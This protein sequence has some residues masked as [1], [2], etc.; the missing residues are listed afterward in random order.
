MKHFEKGNAKPELII[1]LAAPVGT[2]LEQMQEFI[3]EALRAYRYETIPVRVSNLI[4]A[5]CDDDTR[6]LISDAK[7]DQRIDLLMDAGDAIRGHMN[8]GSALVPVICT[9]I[10]EIRKQKLGDFGYKEDLENLE[11][12]NH[13][14]VVNS[15]K[16]PDEVSALRAV[17][18][19]KIVFIS[20]FSGVE[21][22]EDRLCSIIAKSEGS[23]ENHL[24]RDRA[25][26]L[27]EK[28]AKRPGSSIGQNLSNTFH[29]AD[30][31]VR[32][33]DST[34]EDINRFL[35]LYFANPYVTPFRD[36]FF[37]Y[38]AKS[39]SFR[40][41]DMSRQ[42]GA[43]ITTDCHHIVSRGCNEVP[44]VGGGAYWPDRPEQYDNRDFKNG[45]DF[46]A[47]KKD[48]V[49]KELLEFLSKEDILRH[50][51]GT[52]QDVAYELVFG[53]YKESF[54]NLRISNLIEF[55]RVVHAEMAALMEAARRGLS[56]QN[57]ILYCTT[58][59][60]HMCSRH[61]ISA[62]IKRVV[63]IEPYP[64]S[65]TKELFPELVSIDAEKSIEKDHRG[66]DFEQV[67][68]VPFE[69]VAPRLYASLFSAGKR[70]NAEGYIVPW[71]KASAKP[72]IAT[73]STAH[74]ALEL[75]VAKRVDSLTGVKHKASTLTEGNGDASQPGGDSPAK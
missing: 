9:Q 61:V 3:S 12:Y 47:V 13:C 70:K 74:L 43:V 6:E 31:F 33:G 23:T 60:C 62:G 64:K 67:F 63:Y 26:L 72:K 36:E 46:N 53:Q 54:K 69:G 45:R 27:I 1:A 58:F 40:S 16:H 38:E 28:D 8:S 17:Y 57:G 73:L 59:P 18:G 19:D 35:K 34:Q 44:V 75:A 51:V 5:Y 41:S 66:G 21:K 50:D 29:L 4:Q 14:F 42:V 25:R 24:Y 39:N 37:M 55:G 10:R 71:D 22:R 52:S 15:L 56:V 7:G 30:F 49:L 48:Q 11:L 65:M 2:D 68:F 32:V 20:A